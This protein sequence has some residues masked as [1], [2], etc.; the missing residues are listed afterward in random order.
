MLLLLTLACA[1]K[2]AESTPPDESTPTGTTP[3]DAVEVFG[4]AG[5]SCGPVDQPAVV[6]TFG[7]PES[8][9]DAQAAQEQLVRVAV[10]SGAPLSGRY[11]VG[12]PAVGSAFTGSV[13][14][15]SGT[16]TVTAWEGSDAAATISGHYELV[17]AGGAEVH[18]VFAA[19]P[20]CPSDTMMC[21]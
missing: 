10:W 12:D 3:T 5:P 21:G 7:L 4:N 16:L 19:V 14:V 20:W 17:I 8:A 2:A 18:A 13:A 11:D 1:D 9:C 6:F 15:E